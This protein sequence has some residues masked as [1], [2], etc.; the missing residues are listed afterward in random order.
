M[1]KHATGCPRSRYLLFAAAAVFL[2]LLAALYTSVY[3][4]DGPARSRYADGDVLTIYTSSSDEL[5]NAT[6]PLFEEKYKIQVVLVKGETVDLLEK[7]RDGSDAPQA[8]VLLGGVYSELYSYA[9]L[10]QDYVSVN[11]KHLIDAYQN[12][13]GYTTSYILSGSCLVVNKSLTQGVEIKGYRDLLKPEL[14][15]KI[16]MANPIN[17]SSALAQL[18]NILLAMGGY[19]NEEAWDYLSALICQTGEI[20]SA[21]G[22]VYGSVASGKKAVGLSY[23]APCAALMSSG[24]DIEI[25]YPEEGCVYLPATAAIVKGCGQTEYARHFIDFITSKDMQN[26]YGNILMNRSVRKDAQVGKFLLPMDR[27]DLL[28]EDMD[29]VKQHKMEILSRY[30]NIVSDITGD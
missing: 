23:E 29:Y 11:D 7:I 4:T 6:I 21:S 26:I 25:V 20:A 16:I 15:G 13:T 9:D 24:A 19:E 5:L 1:E 18:T 2:L 10:F 8:D 3:R 30:S 28:E 22:K 17:S 14:S 12:T 27:I